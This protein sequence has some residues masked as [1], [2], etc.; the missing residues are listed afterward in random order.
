MRK[1]QILIW[2]SIVALILFTYIS[3]ANNIKR[4]KF[5]EDD[6]IITYPNCFFKGTKSYIRKSNIN[7]NKEVIKS[8]KMPDGIELKLF[9]KPNWSGRQIQASDMSCINEPIGSYIVNTN[10]TCKS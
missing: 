9:E 6:Y 4:E 3:V 2:C 5:S 10:V 7:A 1:L 8:V